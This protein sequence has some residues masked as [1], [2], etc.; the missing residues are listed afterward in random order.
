[1]SRRRRRVRVKEYKGDLKV[2]V[3]VV[4][5][6]KWQWSRKV[7]Q[8]FEQKLDPWRNFLGD[9]FFFLWSNTTKDGGYC[10]EHVMDIC[11]TQISLSMG[12]WVT[13]VPLLNSLRQLNDII[14]VSLQLVVWNCPQ[15]WIFLCPTA[16]Q[17]VSIYP[18]RQS[19]MAG[20]RF[21]WFYLESI[22]SQVWRC[23]TGARQGS[24]SL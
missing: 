1:M 10:V 3:K 24:M 20:Q 7:E 21:C 4:Y 22:K 18:S 15:Y 2:E 13:A 14:G 17:Q 23:R 9:V 6:E 19:M 5:L 8:M 16:S 11:Q 12:H